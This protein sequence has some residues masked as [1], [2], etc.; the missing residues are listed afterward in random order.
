MKFDDIPNRDKFKLN[1]FL[2]EIEGVGG[3]FLKFRKTGVIVN[4]RYQHNSV[5]SFIESIVVFLVIICFPPS[6]TCFLFL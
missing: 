1:V 6:Q 3:W 2:L 5:W 4:N